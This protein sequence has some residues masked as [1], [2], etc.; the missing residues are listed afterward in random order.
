MYPSSLGEDV[1][2]HLGV[3]PLGLMPE[4]DA[5]LEQLSNA[6]FL[7]YC[8]LQSS[9]FSFFQ[10]VVPPPALRNPQG[11]SMRNI[12]RTTTWACLRASPPAGVCDQNLTDS[13]IARHRLLARSKTLGPQ[14]KGLPVPPDQG[15]T[16]EMPSQLGQGV[17]ED[18]ANTS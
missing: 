18:L 11:D 17:P 12:P 7:L 9:C 3:P 16:L 4:V 10:V 1:L 6:Y 8:T 5:S 13:S 14:P 2:L 15:G